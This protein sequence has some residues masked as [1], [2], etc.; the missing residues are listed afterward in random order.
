MIIHEGLSEKLNI[1]FPV[2]TSG[3]FDGVHIGHQTILKRIKDLAIKEGGET[4]MLTFWPH[5]RI[6]L[7]K[8][9][10]DS[11][12]L[13]S[14]FEEKAEKLKQ[15]GIDH[16]IKIP[17]TK[18]FSKLTSQ[19]FIEDILI[20]KIGS[21]VLVIGYDHKFG[22]NREGGFESLQANAD[23]YGF[24][25]EEISR[26]DI[27]DIGVSS[28]KIRKALQAG[29]VELAKSFLGE[30]YELNGEVVQGERLGRT[31]GFPT[32]NLSLDFKHKLIPKDGVYAVYAHVGGKKYRGMLNIGQ[33]PTVSN[34]GKKSIEVHIL[35]F[36]SD[37][38]G[39][40]MRIDMVSRVRDEQAFKGKDALVEQLHRDREDIEKLLD[41]QT[42]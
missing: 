39:E 38:Y 1:R 23:R 34:Q 14:S 24:R 41:E 7:E 2:V 13:L 19:E 35:D 28:T 8:E 37:I 33:R 32:A 12:Q 17:F 9:S 6:V 3:T 4:V 10:E 25:V 22:K 26:Q 42:K 16:L 21:K 27:D 15:H 30:Y 29:D 18:S 31:L 20:E 40:S 5:P 11:L 36:S